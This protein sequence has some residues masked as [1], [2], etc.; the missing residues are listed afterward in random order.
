MRDRPKG[1]NVAAYEK[2]TGRVS[3]NAA[4]VSLVHVINAEDPGV[5]DYPALPLWAGC[6]QKGSYKRGGRGQRR[7]QVTAEAGRDGKMKGPPANDAHTFSSRA[8]LLL[9]YMANIYQESVL[10]QDA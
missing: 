5:G 2:L 7:G 8:Q 10:C 9:I 1:L 6:S 3:P 4:F